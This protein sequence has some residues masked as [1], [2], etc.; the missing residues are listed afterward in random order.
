M[1]LFQLVVRQLS[2]CFV[3]YLLKCLFILVYKKIV[4]LLLQDIVTESSSF[5]LVAFIPLLRD[6]IYTPNSFAR[7][8]VVSWVSTLLIWTLLVICVLIL[9]VQEFPLIILDKYFYAF[10]LFFIFLRQPLKNKK[11]H[12]K[13]LCCHSFIHF[14]FKH[15][16]SLYNNLS[17]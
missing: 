4:F 11:R 6:R 5:D 7:Q 14:T 13:Y 3:F 8:F 16:Y 12:V 2:I 10:F 15:G 9:F 17:E 1:K